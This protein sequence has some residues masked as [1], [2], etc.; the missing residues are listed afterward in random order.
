MNDDLSKYRIERAFE[1]L[2]E[3]KL[4]NQNSFWNASISRLYYAAYFAVISLLIKNNI[5]SNTHKGVRIQFGLHF[6]QTGIFSKEMGKT[7]TDIFD[8]R[9]QS[10]YDDFVKYDKEFVDNLIPEIENF[11]NTIH[12][13]LNEI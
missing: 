10:D 12:L 11:I 9:Q 7:Y 3:A 4:L 6:V 5:Q 1:A 2:N 8:K 13:Y